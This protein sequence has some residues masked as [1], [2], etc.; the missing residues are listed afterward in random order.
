M[1]NLVASSTTE[2]G[3]SIR[4]TRSMIETVEGTTLPV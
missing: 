1:N 2:A 4:Q 3:F